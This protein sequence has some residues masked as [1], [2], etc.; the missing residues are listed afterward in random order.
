MDRTAAASPEFE[1]FAADGV[2]VLGGAAAILLQLADPVVAQGVAAHSAFARDP[3][4]RL[5]TTLS[6]VYSISLGTGRQ[7]ERMAQLVDRSHQGVPGAA[8]PERQL[9]VAA[10]LYRVGVELYELVRRP[11]PVAVADEIHVAFER[12]GTALQVPAGAWPADRASFETYWTDA[13]AGLVVTDPARTVARQLLH[14]RAIPWWTQ[15][16]MPLVRT[17]TTG[18]LP[19]RIRDAYGLSWHPRR[20]RAVIAVVRVLAWLTPRRLSEL[21]SRRLLARIPAH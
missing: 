7:A 4:R 18:L 15:P 9:W 14:P 8:D 6:Y 17:V 12:L 2:L 20:F 19:D 16:A 1:A 21:P 3:M 5:R 10:T 13:V 11:L